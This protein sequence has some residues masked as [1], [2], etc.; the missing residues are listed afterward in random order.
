MIRF[1][2]ILHPTDF[3][4]PAE[5]AGR[6]AAQLAKDHDARLVLL[7]VGPRPPSEVGGHIAYP[8]QPEEYDRAGLE[9]SLAQIKFSD[10]PK[11]IER[12]VVFGAAADSILDMATE[13]G[14]DLIVMGTHGRSGILRVVM[15][16]V[17]ESVMRHAGCPVLTLR[18]PRK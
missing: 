1:S 2:C 17:A 4:A 7:H 5:Y 10:S 16:S 13:Y 8:A 14:A 6:F 18:Q 15:G 3:S 12:R 9:A 11:A